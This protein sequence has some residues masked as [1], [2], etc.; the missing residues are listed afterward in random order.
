MNELNNKNFLDIQKNS[1]NV[2]C[3]LSVDLTRTKLQSRIYFLI[4]LNGHQ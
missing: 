2:N 3:C 1:F 4:I